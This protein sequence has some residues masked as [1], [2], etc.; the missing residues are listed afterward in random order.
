MRPLIP[1]F[2]FATSFTCSAQQGTAPTIEREK[3]LNYQ[4]VIASHTD[5]IFLVITVRN[6]NT[7]QRKEVCTKAAFL[8]GALLEE[9]GSIDIRK[10]K[11]KRYFQFRKQ[12]ALENVGYFDYNPGAIT[13]LEREFP[14]NA[15]CDK[16][17]QLGTWSHTFQGNEHPKM[18]YL[19]HILFNRG[20][21][22]WE[23]SCWGG[24]LYFI[25]RDQVGKFG[26][27]D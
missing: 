20:F 18:D 12:S 16:I 3:L 9:F 19:A 5:E 7:G 11:D 13:K 24:T 17:K 2:L 23:S 6:L 25:R 14:V 10:Y 4:S 26:S 22:T 21:L 27:G 8:Y 15:I 1:I